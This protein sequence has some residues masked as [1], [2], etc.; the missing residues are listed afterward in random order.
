MFLATFGFSFMGLFVKKLSV[1][2]TT[3]EILFY[4]N[5]IGIVWLIFSFS[6]RPPK[7]KGGKFFLLLSRGF[8]GFLGL[9]LFFY[10][11]SVMSLAEAMTFT[12]TAPIFTS[13]FSVLFL[14][15]MVSKKV[16]IAI[17]CCFIG[18]L[19]MSSNFFQSKIFFVT[20][21]ST[22]V[23][24]GLAYTLVRGLSSYYGVRT[25]VFSFTF[26]GTVIPFLFL[27]FSSR[28]Y[29]KNLDF[30]ISGFHK[31]A[32]VD[33]FYIFLIGVFSIISQL[34]MTKAYSLTKAAIVSVISYFTIP[35]S[36]VLG[37]MIGEQLPDFYVLL[38][39]SFIVISGV[40]IST[41]T[42]KDSSIPGFR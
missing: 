18:V 15:E 40:F 23:I 1:S 22:G 9:S 14:K 20:G 42:S 3:T 26:F 12:R 33:W 30:L 24:G 16:W 13:F 8:I 32:F 2:L 4:R 37:I 36:I 35:I 11:I 38:G 10:N 6:Q 21:I 5:L 19:F 39:M 41:Q 31:P 7:N 29:I 34:A 28:I 17:F 27:C 25:I